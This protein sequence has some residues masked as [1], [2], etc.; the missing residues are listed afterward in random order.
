MRKA[1]RFLTNIAAKL[2]HP[3]YNSR[4][5][6]V[7]TWKGIMYT[8]PTTR[9]MKACGLSRTVGEGETLT[10]ALRN[11]GIDLYPGQITMLMG[12]SGSGKSTLLA[13]LS[14]LLH[15]NEGRVLALDHDLWGMSERQRENFRLK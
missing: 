10:V 11:V 1:R 6:T 9:T 3:G 2:F 4:S 8:E 12:P 5:V 15:P 13:V 7:K 14:G